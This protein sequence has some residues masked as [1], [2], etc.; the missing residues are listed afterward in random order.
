M[1]NFFE[2]VSTPQGSTTF[3]LLLVLAFIAFVFVKAQYKKQLDWRDLITRTNSNKVSL[4]KILQLIGG[5]TATW[6]IIKTTVVTNG[7]LSWELFTAYLAY[8]GSVEAYSK[9]VAN[10]YNLP[11]NA[12]APINPQ[13]SQQAEALPEEVEGETSPALVKP[14]KRGKKAEVAESDERIGAAKAQ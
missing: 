2:W 4:S 10:R 8:V 12:S 13:Q 14:A 3:M 9:F 5:I 1:D 7:Q 6:V 11:G